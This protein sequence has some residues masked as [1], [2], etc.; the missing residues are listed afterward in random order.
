MTAIRIANIPPFKLGLISPYAFVTL[1]SNVPGNMSGIFYFYV[2]GGLKLEFSWVNGVGPLRLPVEWIDTPHKVLFVPF[3]GIGAWFND[4]YTYTEGTTEL[5]LIEPP[6]AVST[7]THKVGG[8]CLKNGSPFAGLIHVIS[9]FDQVHLGTAQASPSTG[10]WA[11]D[12]ATSGAVFVFVYDNY[13]TQFAPA[14]PVS[15]GDIVHPSAANKFVYEV[16]QPGVM[17]TTEPAEWPTD[18]PLASGTALMSPVAFPGPQV[19]G[20]ITPAPIT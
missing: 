1:S 2:V 10:A 5:N 4:S 17:D 9:Q 11:L 19:H 20:P 7:P 18:S 8:T 16:T 3:D 15:V 12:V 13:G 6:G 14:L